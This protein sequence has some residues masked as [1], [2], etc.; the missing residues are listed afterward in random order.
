VLQSFDTEAEAEHA[1]WLL[2]L[3]YVT[4]TDNAPWILWS[5]EAAL[6]VAAD[7]HEE[8]A[9]FGTGAEAEYWGNQ[10]HRLCKRTG[11]HHWKLGK[12]KEAA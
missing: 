10:L 1:Y 2:L 4:T 9:E 6:R 12:S 8:A 5:D 11:I 7:N 3:H